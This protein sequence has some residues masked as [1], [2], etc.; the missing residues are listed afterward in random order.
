MDRAC[1]AWE[2][3]RHMHVGED[4]VKKGTYQEAETRAF[5]KKQA[6]AGKTPHL[7][8]ITKSFRI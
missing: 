7:N 2:V 5:K 4:N 6:P 8:F 1:E 3:I